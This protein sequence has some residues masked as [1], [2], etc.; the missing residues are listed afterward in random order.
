[1][2]SALLLVA[3]GS[4]RAN[5]NEEVE[6]V[7][8]RLRVN[9]RTDYSLFEAAF[10]ASPSIE[11]GISNCVKQGIIHI[12]LVPYFLAGGRHVTVDIPAIVERERR[13]YPN[14]EIELAPHLGSSLLI[15]DAI[16]AVAVGEQEAGQ[17]G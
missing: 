2:T 5:S 9:Y 3:H 12:R 4:R 6:R 13:K 8:E 16:M 1:M 7:T 17:A 11:E 15:E 10:L 14:V